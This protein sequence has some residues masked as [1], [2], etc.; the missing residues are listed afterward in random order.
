L[1][2]SSLL[3]TKTKNKKQKLP[4]LTP[5]WV[6]SYDAFVGFLSIA[7]LCAIQFPSRLWAI[8]G[9]WQYLWADGGKNSQCWY[10]FKHFMY[11]FNLYYSKKWKVLSL[12][13]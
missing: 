11:L 5:P 9:Q 8:W 6:P 12:L 2:E 10:C 3:V 13:C 1:E 7:S 4:P